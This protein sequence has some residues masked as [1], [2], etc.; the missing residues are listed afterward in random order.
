MHIAETSKGG[1]GTVMGELIRDQCQRYGRDQVSYLVPSEHAEDLGLDKLPG[2][3]IFRRTG[4]NVRSLLLLWRETLS[5]IRMLRPEIVHLH[6]TF[7]GLIGRLAVLT[8]PRDRRPAIIYCPH[9]FA[10][11]QHGS[12]SKLTAYRLAERMLSPMAAKIICVSE[13]ERQEGVQAGI[14][15]DRLCV[16]YNGVRNEAGSGEQ[17]D[18]Y[19]P[20]VTK[21]LLF[22]GRFDQQKGFDVLLRAMGELYGAPVRL[23]A[24]GAAVVGSTQPPNLPN[25]TYTGWIASRKLAPYFMFADALIIP[26]RWEGFAMVPLEAMQYGLC[27]I[28]SD[29]CSL[30]E[31]VISGVNGELFPSG[32]WRALAGTI[33]NGDP[34]AWRKLGAQG[35]HMYQEKFTPEVMSA[36]TAAVYEQLCRGGTC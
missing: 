18:P 9:A 22:V 11:L 2:A 7:A 28:A 27:V 29:A 33:Q 24:I 35:R 15:A 31:Q 14:D 21:N 4:R 23:T 16:I 8:L 17:L 10:F 26:S 32:D 20:G 19:L 25:V 1:V 12:R 30:P 13:F 34:G 3:Y 5:L 36:Q 6:S